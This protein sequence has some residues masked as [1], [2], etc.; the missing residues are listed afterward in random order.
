M[1]LTI[2]FS[3]RENN[4]H[5]LTMDKKSEEMESD[6]SDSEVEAQPKPIFINNEYS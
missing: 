6:N 4:I 2:N 3:Y 5:K 1:A